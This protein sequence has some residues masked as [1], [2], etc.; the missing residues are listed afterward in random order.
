MLIPLGILASSGGGAAGSFE[1][2]STTILSTTAAS[3][4]F[5]TTGLGST[6]KHLQIRSTIRTDKSVGQSTFVRL[7]GDSGSNY[8]FHSLVGN[9]SSVTS[10]ATT[11]YTSAVMYL[12]STPGT[13]TTTGVFEPGIIDILDAFSTSK[14]KTLKAVNGNQSNVVTNLRFTSGLWM[15]TAAITSILISPET[16]NFIAGSRFSLYGIKG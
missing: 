1:L 6:Y 5:S 10:N 16:N 15:N 2:I 3:V 4:T 7:N 8:A 14:N 12:G 11:S 9:G 13:N